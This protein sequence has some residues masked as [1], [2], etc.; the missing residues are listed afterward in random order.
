[1]NNGPKKGT[2]R[3]TIEALTSSPGLKATYQV[4]KDVRNPAATPADEFIANLEEK[5]AGNLLWVSVSSNADTY[6]V[7]IP[8]S[9][10]RTTY[11]T[12][13]K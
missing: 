8:A 5:C 9:G 7:S 6:S 2:A 4:H 10:H 12:K 1:M 11:E 13:S 3:G